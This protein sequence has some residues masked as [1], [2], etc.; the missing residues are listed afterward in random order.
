MNKKSVLS[1]ERYWFTKEEEQKL[2]RNN[3]SFYCQ[4]PAQI[5][6]TV[7]IERKHTNWGNVYQVIVLH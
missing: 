6:V 2:Q 7:G 1:D 4:S 3:L 5:L